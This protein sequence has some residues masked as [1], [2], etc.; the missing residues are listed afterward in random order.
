MS[1]THSHQRS[2][3][4]LFFS[5]ILNIFIT[6][7]QIVGGFLSG[8]LALLSD[9]LHNFTDVVSLIISYVAAK[10]SSKSATSNMTFGYKRAEIIAAFINSASLIIIAIILI[11]ES[12]IHFFDPKV[13]NSDLVIWLSA[14]AIV[15][16]GISVLLL[17]KD[18]KTNM[19][20]S[21]AYYHL[22]TD[23]LASVAV[24]GGGLLMKFY[25]IYWVDS[26]LTF[27]IAVYL[28]YV[29]FKLFKNSF[30]VL[31]L[32][33]PS[34][35]EIQ[36]IVAKINSL[37]LVKNMH[38]VHIWQLNEV[39]LHLEAEIDF[40]EDISLSKFDEILESI[41]HILLNEYGI[42]HITIQPEFNKSDNKNIIVQD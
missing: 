5:I 32:F 6:V 29:G 38:H 3:K 20:L 39:E 41:E 42:N 12:V 19:N 37:P 13:I 4:N 7:S 31:M 25:G 27:L 26:V 1:H 21:S 16:N 40:E 30:S 18:R 17:L 34:D 35:I 33:T 14:L 23:M 2:Q 24:L 36:S 15:G 9:A 28:I 22:L 8:S 11:K 10:Y